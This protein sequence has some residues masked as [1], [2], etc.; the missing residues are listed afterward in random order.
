M[1]SKVTLTEIE[2]TFNKNFMYTVL[3]YASGVKNILFEILD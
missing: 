3:D 2:N 1:L